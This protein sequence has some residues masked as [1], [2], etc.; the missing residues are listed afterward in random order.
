MKGFSTII[1][2]FAFLGALHS[3][4]IAGPL[5]NDLCSIVRGLD[6]CPSDSLPCSYET[7]KAKNERY[8][9]YRFE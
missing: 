4:P 9:M 8:G 7:I 2:S 3:N 6:A 1:I 5:Q